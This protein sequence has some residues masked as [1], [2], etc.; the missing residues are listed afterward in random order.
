METL[1][2]PTLSKLHAVLSSRDAAKRQ[3]GG[4]GG[5]GGWASEGVAD[6]PLAGHLIFASPPVPG[7][8]PTVAKPAAPDPWHTANER[9]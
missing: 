3:A 6:V 1:K 7:P 9:H 2:P 8:G 5:A 4:A